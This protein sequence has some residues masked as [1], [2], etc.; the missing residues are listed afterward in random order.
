MDPLKVQDVVFTNGGTRAA[1]LT[2]VLKNVKSYGF[3]DCEI[4]KTE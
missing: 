4:D 3:N 2:V 1:A